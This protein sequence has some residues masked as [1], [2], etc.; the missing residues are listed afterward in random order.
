MDTLARFDRRLAS[1][2]APPLDIAAIV[3]AQSWNRLPPAVRRRFALAHHD[4][5][6]TGALDLACSRV[7]R[8]FALLTRVLGGPL[9]G[10]R[11]DAVPARVRVYGDGRGGVVWERHLSVAAGAATRV[12]RS[13]KLKGAART[14]IERTDGG[15]SMELD[16]FEEDGALVFKSRRYFLALGAW[17]LPIP[18]ALTPGV[19]RVEHRDQGDGRFRF[20]LTMVHPWWGRTF[21]QTGLFTD[22]KEHV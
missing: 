17:R 10:V 11:S 13:T 19:C 2:P 6:Y 4:C 12:V 8:C 21:H 5:T 16:V 9:T 1:E 15:L 18:T 22:P 3:G 7:G 14:L 20:T